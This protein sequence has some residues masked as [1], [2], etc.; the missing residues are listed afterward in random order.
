MGID[1]QS[2]SVPWDIEVARYSFGASCGPVAFAVAIKAEV[3]DV[4]QFFPQFA[5]NRRWTN[6]VQMRAALVTVA[7]QAAIH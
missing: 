4:M 5:Q 6:S 3:C 2:R 7:V 1:P